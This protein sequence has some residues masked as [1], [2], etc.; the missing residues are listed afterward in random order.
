MRVEELRAGTLVDGKRVIGKTPGWR[1]KQRIVTVTYAVE[2]SDTPVTAIY[3]A[4][5]HV[6]GSPRLSAA[7][8]PASNTRARHDGQRTR[9]THHDLDESATDRRERREAA[10]LALVA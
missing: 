7:F 1:N 10:R 6:P 3:F 5:Q 9:R 4:G 8:L 2:G